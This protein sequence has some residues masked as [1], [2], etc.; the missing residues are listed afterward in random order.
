MKVGLLHTPAIAVKRAV[1]HDVS[2]LGI[3]TRSTLDT[4]QHM[5]PVFNATS[6]CQLCVLKL[7]LVSP[8]KQQ[9]T[10]GEQSLGAELKNDAYVRTA[11]VSLLSS[12]Q[13]QSG[14][15]AAHLEEASPAL[16]FPVSPAPGHPEQHLDVCNPGQRY[17]RSAEGHSQGTGHGY[18][19]WRQSFTAAYRLNRASNQLHRLC[20]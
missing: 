12:L 11:P 18:R 4:G 14:C 19:R 13:V 7:V 3:L 20:F 6:L 1:I 17:I 9:T 16:S 2:L 8:R 5:C 10:A 15:S